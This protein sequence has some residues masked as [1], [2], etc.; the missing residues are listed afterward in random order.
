M[1][2]PMVFGRF[3]KAVD[4]CDSFPGEGGGRGLANYLSKRF[5]GIILKHGGETPPCHFTDHLAPP[6]GL[7]LPT[8]H[9]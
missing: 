9:G 1:I 6:L 4:V 7:S 8:K 2:T 3:L 5:K